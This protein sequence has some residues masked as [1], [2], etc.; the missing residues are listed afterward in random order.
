MKLCRIYQM[1]WNNLHVLVAVAQEGSLA[2]AARVLGVNHATISRRVA[3]LEAE[4]GAGLVRRLARSTPLTE[5]GRQIV[6]LAMDMVERARQIE[7]LIH[8]QTNRVSGTVR[9][10]APPSM[11]SGT[12]MPVLAGVLGAHP[13]LRLDLIA[14][15]R[16]TSLEQGEADIAIRLTEPQS[17]QSIARKLG[18]ITYGLYGTA[19]H[20]GQPEAAWRF[21]AAGPGLAHTPAQKWLTAFAAGRPFSLMSTDPHVQKAAAETGLGIA[22]LPDRIAGQSRT[23]LKAHASAPPARAAWLV[24]HPDVQ[25]SPA[26]RIVAE[27]ISS[28]FR[29][30][31]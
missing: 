31:G 21:I 27:E 6:D 29:L 11:F 12:L 10:S 25:N 19:D 26:V 20:I 24:M 8:L 18:E 2:G 23:L 28:V 22:L 3:A 9:L 5:K 15:S 7:R 4:V 17:P 13:D 1:D 16:I 14:D 30:N